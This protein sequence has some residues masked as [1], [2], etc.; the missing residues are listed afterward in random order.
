M[1]VKVL[2][3]LTEKKDHDGKKKI[4]IIL[5]RGLVRATS[6]VKNTLKMLNLE[7]KNYCSIVLNTEAN[8]GMIDVV[9]SFVTY[10]EIEDDTLKTLLEKRGEKRDEKRLKPFFRLAPPVGG[11]ERKGIKVPF[12]QGGALGYR[13]ENINTLIKKMI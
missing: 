10:G 1:K 5:V 3:K 11:F 8:M 4:A 9:R 6:K 13:G 7:R 12:S 2:S